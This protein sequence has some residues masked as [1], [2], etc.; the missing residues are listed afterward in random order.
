MIII[1]I[2]DDTL[3]M[4]EI[5]LEILRVRRNKA[6]TFNFTDLIITY[7]VIPRVISDETMYE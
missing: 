2:I 6:S 7:L 3:I 4:N 5:E 1:V